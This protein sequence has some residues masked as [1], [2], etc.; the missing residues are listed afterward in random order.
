ML[1][2][3]PSN[4]LPFS[5]VVGI[6]TTS[7]QEIKIVARDYSKPNS[8]YIV[9]KAIVNGFRLFTLK[10]PLSPTTMSLFIFN[11]RNGNLKNDQDP[12]FKIV[13]LSVQKLKT[14]PMWQSDDISSFVEFAEEF[15]QN[16]GVI[17]AGD[18][19]PCIYRSNNGK[20]CIDY[21][22]KI[23]N[24]QAGFGFVSTPAR[25]G[26]SSGI[27]EVSQADFLKYSIP[28]R[29][30][31][32]C[33]E[34]SHKYQNGLVN[35]ATGDEIGADIFGANI[36]LSRGFSSLEFLMA[37]AI[38]FR[39]ANNSFNA[40]RLKIITDF[41]RKFANGQLANNCVTDYRIKQAA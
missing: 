13:D 7:P 19:K 21:Y 38:V 26:H 29:F 9:R 37:F 23:P 39:T 33:H 15:C 28:M 25:V 2:T 41:T 18:V 31:I 5:L 17:S 24:K 36:F 11:T 22:K 12:T 40:K 27:I 1:F 16:A 10:F 34:F 30:A 4:K 32:L 14:C 8:D 6:R 20:F 35:R 3:I